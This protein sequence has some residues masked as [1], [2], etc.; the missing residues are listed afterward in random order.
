MT[1]IV[2]GIIHSILPALAAWDGEYIMALNAWVFG[3]C[4]LAICIR[5]FFM[6]K[7]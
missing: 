7:E 2:V 3:G 4:I 6:E 5:F 1:F